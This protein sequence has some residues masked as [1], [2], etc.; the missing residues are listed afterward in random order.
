MGYCLTVRIENII[1]I[2]RTAAIVDREKAKTEDAHAQTLNILDRVER[3]LEDFNTSMKNVISTHIFTIT[4][5]TFETVAT[6][7]AK[8]FLKTLSQLQVSTESIN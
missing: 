7:P 1:E 2:S 8:F 6:A 4:I 5:S 3:V